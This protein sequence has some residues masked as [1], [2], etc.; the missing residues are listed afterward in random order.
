MEAKELMVG[1]WVMIENNSRIC[2]IAEDGVYFADKDG[3]GATSFDRIAPIPIIGDIFE[4]NGFKKIP[5][6]ENPNRYYWG[7]VWKLEGTGGQ[8]C[9]NTDE[10]YIVYE[11]GWLCIGT[12]EARIDIPIMYVH[13]L[14]HAYRLAGIDKEI[15]L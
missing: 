3:R 2:A 8:T 5:Y 11:N 7:I 13:Q 10:K 6:K 1:D 9:S 12:P 15:V 4:K 14:Q